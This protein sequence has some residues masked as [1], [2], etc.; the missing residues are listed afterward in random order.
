ML[1]RKHL[2]RDA[3]ATEP[4]AGKHQL[5]EEAVARRVQ[6]ARSR[7]ATAAVQA[8]GDLLAPGGVDG[9]RL[10]RLGRRRQRH[11]HRGSHPASRSTR[12][13]AVPH[14][15]TANLRAATAVVMALLVEGAEPWG[16]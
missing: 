4:Y 8:G 6:A 5:E 15:G 9:D 13:Q 16:D 1:V 14:C 3:V 2:Q 10:R 12:V 7:V 11:S